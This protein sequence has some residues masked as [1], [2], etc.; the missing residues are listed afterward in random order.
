MTDTPS[1]DFTPF[2][3]KMRRAGLAEL[4]IDNFQY[5]Y[6]MLASGMAGMISESTIAPVAHVPAQRDMHRYVDAGRAA[7]GKTALLKLNGGLGTSMGLEQAKSLLPVRDGMSFL[8]IIIRQNLEARASLDTQLPLCFMNSFNTDADTH[9]VLANYPALAQLVPLT[10]IQNKVPKIRRDTLQPVE[11]ASDP[12]LEWCPPG[13]GDLYIALQTSGLLQQLLAG[14]YEYLFV[15][16]ADNLGATLDLSIL[17]YLAQEQV[18]FLMEVA[19]RTEADKKGGHIARRVDGRLVLRE[20]AQ[21][22]KDDLDAFQDIAR[23][24][25]FNTN[26]IWLDLRALRAAL[27]AH[28]NVIKLPMIRNQKTADPRDPDSTPV[29]QLETAMG[30]A[31]EVFAGAQVLLVERERFVPVKT[32]ADLLAIRSDIY[33]IDDT[34]HLQQN[35]AR[36]LG[37]I[38]IDLDQAYY[39]LID[40]FEARFPSGVPSLIDC[41][42]LAV[43]GDVLFEAGTICRGAVGISNQRATQQ[44]LEAGTVLADQQL[45]F[46]GESESVVLTVYT[47]P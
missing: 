2:R 44:R 34:Y 7:V 13:H 35:P 12:E 21:C 15:S 24:R 9:R 26:N 10:M 38:V 17:G 46:P 20:V 40:G 14:G 6:E 25:Y 31:I 47:R 4:V 36:T 23:Y 8:D 32:C 19:A 27:A 30:A 41:A 22:P 5:Y 42:R 28:G 18:P 33:A 37:T 43:G 3:E 16:N 39:K 45:V 1:A 11:V 29:F